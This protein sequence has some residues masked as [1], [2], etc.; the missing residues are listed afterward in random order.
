VEGKTKSETG[1]RT[2]WNNRVNKFSTP[3]STAIFMTINFRMLFLGSLFVVGLFNNCSKPTSKTDA[4]KLPVIQAKNDLPQMLVTTIDESKINTRELQGNNIIVL[5]QSDC[6][7]CQRE[8]KE[9]RL[10]L[11]AFK[12]YNVYFITSDGKPAVEKIA[13]DYDLLGHSNIYFALTSTDEVLRNFGPIPAPSMY[14]YANQ[15]LMQKFNGETDIEKI[16]L[17]I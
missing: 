2:L 8:A 12:D 11:D 7:H 15:Q 17:A 6:D 5:F 13:K 1:N 16:L 10:H 9:I 4:V 3:Y 14:I